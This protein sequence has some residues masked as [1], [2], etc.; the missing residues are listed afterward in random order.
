MMLSIV[1]IILAGALL[2][3]L[4]YCEC[5][6]GS[7]GLLVPV[8]TVL[9]ALFVVTVLVRPHPM[10]A[11]YHFLLIGLLFCLAGDVFLALPQDRMFRLGLVSFLVGHIF[12]SVAFF[13]TAPVSAW[14]W[15][16]SLVALI[17]SGWIY[18]WLRPS[19]G[20]MNTPVLAYIVVITVMVSGAVSILGDARLALA[21]RIMIFAGGWCFYASDIFVARDRFVKKEPLNRLIGLPL[22]YGGQFLLAF[23]VGQL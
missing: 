3:C 20:A 16:G 19:L 1:I 12:Y 10:P 22:Y 23:S 9:S 17:V 4:L 7:R 6:E 2:A 5:R 8:K 21:G 14:T 18:L 11:Y 15:W 13:T